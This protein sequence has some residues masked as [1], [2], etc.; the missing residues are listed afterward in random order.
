MMAGIVADAYRLSRGYASPAPFAW[1]A[2]HGAI[3]ATGWRLGRG[4]TPAASE[5]PLGA[6]GAGNG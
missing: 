2:I 3:I 4:G 1:I 6:V 5:A